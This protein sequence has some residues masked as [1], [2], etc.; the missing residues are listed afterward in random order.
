MSMIL[1]GEKIK[2]LRKSQHL[3]QRDLASRLD[4]S[5]STLAAYENDSCA[6]SY[7]VLARIARMFHVTTDY[8][9]LGEEAFPSVS[10]AG[11]SQEQI[12]YVAEIIGGLQTSN[13]VKELVQKE[14]TA[15][16][17]YRR[18]EEIFGKTHPDAEETMKKLIDLSKR[19]K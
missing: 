16:Q 15:A 4:I 13:L 12:H 2:N 7:E 8:L 17:L 5:K 11:L 14:T 3:S 9:I 19:P 18:S 6:P 10:V 1:M